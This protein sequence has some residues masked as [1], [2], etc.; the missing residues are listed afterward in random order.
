MDVYVDQKTVQWLKNNLDPVFGYPTLVRFS[1]STCQE[2]LD[3]KA[4]SIKWADEEDDD[5]P[6]GY[7]KISNFFS[8]KSADGQKPAKRHRFFEEKKLKIVKTI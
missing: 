8:A 4:V 6:T 1:W 2:K 7:C 5:L 3:S